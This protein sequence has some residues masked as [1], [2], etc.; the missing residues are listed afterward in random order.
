MLL[1]EIQKACLVRV[2]DDDASFSRAVSALLSYKGWRVNI[3]NRAEDFLLGDR[4]SY[5]GCLLLD[6]RMPGMTGLQLQQKLNE[7]QVK[8]PIVFLS[9]HGDIDTA[10]H[11]LHEGAADFLQKSCDHERLLTVVG[12]ACLN[13]LRSTYP[14]AYLSAQ[15]A[16]ELLCRLSERESQI[17]KLAALGLSSTQIGE[18]LQ[19]SFRTVETH[20]ASAAKK[21][22]THKFEEVLQ[23]VHIAQDGDIGT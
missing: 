16:R 6:I 23:I 15:E 10:V 17:I 22:G 11:T 12:K 8:L 20:R 21:L 9:A 7:Q 1:D 19:I 13:S 18:R 4:H 14:F 3:Y 5:P 2:V